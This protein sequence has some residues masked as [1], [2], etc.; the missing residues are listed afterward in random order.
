VIG[1]LARVEQSQLRLYLWGLAVIVVGGLMMWAPEWPLIMRTLSDKAPDLAST[2]EE[3]LTAAGYPE[4]VVAESIDRMRYLLDTAIRLIPTGTVMNI[5]AQYSVGC[6]WFLYRGVPANAAV[7]ELRPF[8]LWKAPFGLTPVLIVAILGLQ[9]G[10]ETINLVAINV[11]ATLSIFYCVTGLSFLEYFLKRL[12]M[13]LWLKVVLYIVFVL[14]GL[15]GY[16]GA[17]LLGFIDSFADWRKVSR[18]AIDL[19]NSD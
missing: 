8:S 6:L 10:G 14:S 5:V 11:L 12:K 16:F 13:P 19:N 1:R 15:I 4:A 9:F 18:G 3:I 2:A 7:G 17:A